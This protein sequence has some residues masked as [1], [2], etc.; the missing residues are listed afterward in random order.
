VPVTAVYSRSDGIV[1]WEACLDRWNPG[2]EHVEVKATH[3]GLV[4]S[5]AVYRL[6][7]RKLALPSGR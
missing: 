1:A 7:A 3:L 6:L 2:V 5:P 4:A